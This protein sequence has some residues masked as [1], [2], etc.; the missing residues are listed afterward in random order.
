MSEEREWKSCDDEQRENGRNVK[1]RSG[2][3]NCE[4]A[5]SKPAERNMNAAHFRL[6]FFSR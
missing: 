2:T 1:A 5:M 6:H 3:N 4:I